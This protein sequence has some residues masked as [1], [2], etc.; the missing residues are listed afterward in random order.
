MCPLLEYLIAF[1]KK[2]Q[3]ELTAKNASSPQ[4]KE[5]PA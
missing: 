1:I 5:C 2:Y 4:N 3:E